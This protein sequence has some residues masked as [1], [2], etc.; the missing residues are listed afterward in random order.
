M[1]ALVLLGAVTVLALLAA[2]E[3]A[4]GGPVAK[5]TLPIQIVNLARTW[6]KK[7]QLPLDWVLAT[8]QLESGGNPKA[9]N[10]SSNERSLGLMQVNVNVHRDRLARHGLVEEHLY[11]PNIAIMVGT[12]I[13]AEFKAGV[14]RLLGGKPPPIPL[15]QLVRVAYKG[16]L[17]AAK[18]V[19]AGAPPSPE[20]VAR[21]Q[22][23]VSR[24]A[25]IA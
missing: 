7:R 13:L 17:G 1:T 2:G 24:Y 10:I 16:G 21:W 9:A 8:I 25:G 5:K 22:G 4:S 12:E 14:E 15:D 6:A 20:T 19:L 3:R 11:D 23:A 18:R